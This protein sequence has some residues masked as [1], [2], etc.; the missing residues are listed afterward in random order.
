MSSKGVS[1]NVGEESSLNSQKEDKQNIRSHDNLIE[2]KD[3][4]AHDPTSQALQKDDKPMEDAKGNTENVEV[5]KSEKSGINKDTLEPYRFKA[6]NKFVHCPECKE[7]IPIESWPNHRDRLRTVCAKSK[8]TGLRKYLFNLLLDLF[9]WA[10]VN[11]FYREVVVCGLEN[12]PKEGPVVFYGNHQNQFIDAMMIRAHCGRPVRFII[13]EKSMHRP[14]IGFFA[15]LMEAVP[16]IRPQDQTSNQGQGKI[17]K[18]EDDQVIGEGT[19]FTDGMSR[20]DVISWIVPGKIKRCCGQIRSIESD[21]LLT[22]TLPVAPDDLIQVPTCYKFSRRID[23]SEMYADVYD[24]L[25]KGECIGI[26]PEGGS[27]DRTSLLPLK[28]GVALFS[29][30]AAQRGIFPKI[31]PCG[32]TYYYGHKFRSRAYIEFGVPRRP[33]PEMVDKF[34]ET[35][36]KREVTGEL[37]DILDKAIR[38][39]TIN[40]RDWSSLNFLHSFRRLYQPVNVQLEPRDYLRLTRRLS[41]IINK[42]NDDPEFADFR[43]RVENYNDYCSALLVR[44]S[45]AATLERLEDVSVGLVMKRIIMLVVM[46]VVLV[47]FAIIALPIG[48][49]THTATEAHAK[50]ALSA[51]TVKVVAAD[52]KGSYKI[53]VGFAVV[54]IIINTV[55]FFTYIFFD[56]RTSLTVLFSLPMAMY[57]SL[58]ILRE[59]ILELSAALPLAMSIF[60]KHKQFR[61]LF[62]RRTAIVEHAR[63]IVQKFDSTLEGELAQL[64]IDEDHLRQ[65]SL[66]SLRHYSHKRQGKKV[67]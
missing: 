35:K 37:L 9:L 3:T 57:V 42:Y 20:G 64:E 7:D 4:E 45:Q 10:L 56:L 14:V 38:E 59:F 65:P 28:A 33:T 47:P 2:H 62:D 67:M 13:A 43:T 53:V 66:F 23:H 48:I 11:V 22:L 55:A 1:F 39:V 61:K 24:T 41:L 46:G 12:V 27:H 49:I 17:I 40:V 36:T 29:L 16:V 58:L 18:M 8:L 31:V 44:D 50:T 52:V 5:K 54:P 26:F 34:E 15:R 6:R 51:S 32:L 25:S 30:G 21:T 63:R 60:S 19:T